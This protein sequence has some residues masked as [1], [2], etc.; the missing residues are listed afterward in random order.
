M[1]LDTIRC[2]DLR[3][4][5]GHL[6][7]I[8]SAVLT[9][10]LVATV[11]SNV[12]VFVRLVKVPSKWT[13]CKKIAQYLLCMGSFEAVLSTSVTSTTTVAGKI[14]VRDGPFDIQGGGGLGFFLA[15]SYFFLSFCTTSNFFK[16]KLQQVFYFLKNNTLKSEKCKRKQHIE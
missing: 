2:G 5:P 8:Y 15:T 7:I 10:I 1:A 14:I 9:L 11:S 6:E 12:Y 16:S 3:P 13:S 4:A